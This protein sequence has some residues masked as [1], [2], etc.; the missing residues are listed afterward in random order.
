MIN[1]LTRLCQIPSGS[2]WNLTYRSTEHGFGFDEFHLKCA[3][4]KNCLTIVKSQNGNVF[5]GYID[6]AWNKKNTWMRN[7]N[8][9]LFSL[10]NKD[11]NSLKIKCSVPEKA[12]GGARDK[13]IQYYGSSQVR[14]GGVDLALSSDSN[15]N[16]GSYSNLGNT[17]KH[18]DYSLGSSQAQ[19]FLAGSKRFKTLEIEVYFKL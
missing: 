10:I 18:P 3:D 14:G 7:E 4:Q 15:V 12:A 9:Y 8:A 17:Y 6:G 11:T 13:H 1:D 5:G 2:E 19:Q 16:T